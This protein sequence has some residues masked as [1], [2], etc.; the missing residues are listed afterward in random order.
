MILARLVFISAVME[1]A[2]SSPYKVTRE[3]IRIQMRKM[4]NSL[5]FIVKD[6][7]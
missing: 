5:H 3:T 1:A 2:Y 4:I 7:T 6:E